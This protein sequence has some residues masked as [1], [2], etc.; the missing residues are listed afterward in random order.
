[1]QT[2]TRVSEPDLGVKAHYF[3]FIKILFNNR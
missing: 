2:I 1:M 3:N